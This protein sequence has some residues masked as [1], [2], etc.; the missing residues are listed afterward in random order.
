MKVKLT[1]YSSFCFFLIIFLSG[2]YYYN[3]D[4]LEFGESFQGKIKNVSTYKAT[5][6]INDSVVIDISY[7]NAKH[8][9][10]AL[11]DLAETG[12]SI[13]TEA[14]NDTIYLYKKNGKKYWFI[15]H[16][17]SGREYYFE[18]MNK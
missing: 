12:D 6:Y 10:N 13:S 9:P 5:T 11:D 14:F 7:D 3:G 18:K 2:C 17:N 16:G 8:F 4:Y 15:K 1:Y